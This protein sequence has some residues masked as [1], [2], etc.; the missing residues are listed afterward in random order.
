MS[1]ILSSYKDFIETKEKVY[2]WICAICSFLILLLLIVSVV[3]ITYLIAFSCVM[4]IMQ[5]LFIG[6]LKANAIKLS[7]NQYPEAYEM[8]LEAC[9]KL[10]YM[11]TP[12]IYVLQSGGMLNAL[13]TK[14]CGRN[15]V[16]I[17]SEV[18]EAA[19]NE[20]ADALKFIIAHELAHHKRNHLLKHTFLLPSFLIPFL[21]YAYSRACEYSCDKIATYIQPKNAE[22]GLLIL[23]AGAKLYKKINLVDYIKT[24]QNES[25]FCTWFAEI[26][27]SHPHL[28]KR[29][30]K[31]KNL[32]NSLVNNSERVLNNTQVYSKV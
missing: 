19:Y 30:I 15:F 25:G 6:N 22:D 5:G 27:N 8:A 9:A 20:G 23:L 31:V 10:E 26:F 17:Y 12:E 32:S 13:A 18:L 7:K 11:K 24:S 28:Y 21:A 2:F 16:V 14:F 4:W 1:E 3:G 29:I